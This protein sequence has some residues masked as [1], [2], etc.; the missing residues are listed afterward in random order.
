MITLICLGKNKE[1]NQNQLSTSS[2]VEVDGYY[3]SQ[4]FSAVSNLINKLLFYSVFVT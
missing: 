3:N 1:F 4:G 2:V